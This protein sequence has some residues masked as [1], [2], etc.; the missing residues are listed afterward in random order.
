MWLNVLTVGVLGK[1]VKEKNE[2]EVET[3]R[4]RRVNLH[5]NSYGRF[6]YG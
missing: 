4:E 5:R 6:I 2:E 3:L 1:C